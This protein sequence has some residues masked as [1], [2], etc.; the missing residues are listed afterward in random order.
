MKNLITAILFLGCTVQAFSQWI[1]QSYTATPYSTYLD[2]KFLNSNTGFI[3]GGLL[4]RILKTTNGGNNWALTSLTSPGGDIGGVDFKDM[5]TGIIVGY[6]NSTRYCYKTTNGGDN[7]IPVLYPINRGF[8]GIKFSSQS[9][10]VC[11]GDSGLVLKSTNLGNNWSIIQTPV[12][13]T[14]STIYVIDSSNFFACG[15]K[16]TVIKT[17]DGGNNWEALS[18]GT[19]V[20]LSCIFFTNN[21]TGYITGYS[22]GVVKKTTNGGVSW[23]Y[24]N[25]SSVVDV[26]TSVYFPSANTGYV[27]GFYLAGKYYQNVIFKTTNGGSNWRTLPTP[28]QNFQQLYTIYFVNNDVG[29]FAGANSL[30][31][32]TTTGGLTFV[33]ENGEVV[34]DFSL[35]QNCP[36]PFNPSTKINY[37]LRV[38]NYIS[39]NV[40][41]VNGRLVKEL[42]NEKQNA[43]NYSVDFS[44]EGLPSGVYYY[45]LIADGVVIDT[46]K[47]VLVK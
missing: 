17:T 37:E 16:G 13:K 6:F 34:S 46:K 22:S 26:V 9:T 43:G 36:N 14:L 42:V 25:L 32:K 40:Y 19:T 12:N 29:W 15:E 38:P 35:E 1:D 11:C 7:W 4:G 30:I 10:V 8:Y 23:A 3:V 24:V 5:L 21:N 33:N 31:L 47:A 41:D 39:L 28:P 20:D 2:S 45:S 27:T 18:S 44:G